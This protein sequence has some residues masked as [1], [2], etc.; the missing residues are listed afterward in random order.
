MNT[1]RARQLRNNQ[2]RA[3]RALWQ[4]LR[5]HQV[6]VKFRRQHPLGPY[7]ADFV[8]FEKRLIIEIDG[9]QHQEQIEYDETRTDWL[10]QQGYKILR[11]WNNEILN[12][13]AGVIAIIVIELNL[14]PHPN[15]PP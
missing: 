9:G 13:P 11:F 1:A 7:I 15:P 8:C 3:E 6:G 4:C 14:H 10:Q 12:E 5:K 2:T